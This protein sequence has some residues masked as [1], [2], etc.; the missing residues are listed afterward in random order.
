VHLIAP[1]YLIII[2]FILDVTYLYER[3]LL[4]NADW[5][6]DYGLVRG[7]RGLWIM[8]LWVSVFDVQF[9]IP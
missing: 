4:Q 1:Y 3:N 2:I 7:R 9:L 8:V 5:E 6:S